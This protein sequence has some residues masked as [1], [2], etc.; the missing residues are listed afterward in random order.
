[1]EFSSKNDKMN[2]NS[3]AMI[4]DNIKTVQAKNQQ[5]NLGKKKQETNV[6]QFK[7]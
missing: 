2:L 7:I 5:K 3:K 6:I 4:Y 1:M